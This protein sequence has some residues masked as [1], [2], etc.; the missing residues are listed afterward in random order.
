MTDGPEGSKLS[1]LNVQPRN[2][3]LGLLKA[4]SNRHCKA[5]QLGGST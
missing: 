4:G 3:G 1:Q 5:C 2:Q